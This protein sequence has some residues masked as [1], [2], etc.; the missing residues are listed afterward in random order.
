MG[1]KVRTAFRGSDDG[2]KAAGRKGQKNGKKQNQHA[3]QTSH[4]KKR[5]RYGI[6]RGRGLKGEKG[7]FAI[8]FRTTGAGWFP[9]EGGRKTFGGGSR[10]KNCNVGIFKVGEGEDAR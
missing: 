1:P 10:G 4:S 8:S 9:S 2:H 6:E 5:S 3:T 7:S